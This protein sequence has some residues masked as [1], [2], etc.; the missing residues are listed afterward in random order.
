MYWL[1][2]VEKLILGIQI[3]SY[4]I[5]IIIK[6]VE[7]RHISQHGLVLYIWQGGVSYKKVWLPISSLLQ[8]E[9]VCQLH[10]RVG[11]HRKGSRDRGLKLLM[12]KFWFVFVCVLKVI[13]MNFA[14]WDTL[15]KSSRGRGVKLLW[16]T[17][18]CINITKTICPCILICIWTHDLCW[19][20]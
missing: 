7:P 12:K 6:K 17:N 20:G 3:Y 2:A 19:V 14:V 5:I 4:I 1:K 10:G 9:N 16:N 18:L 8:H 11:D 13:H 15:E